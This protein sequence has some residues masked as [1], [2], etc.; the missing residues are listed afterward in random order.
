[1]PDQT[2]YSPT[3]NNANI[4]PALASKLVSPQDAAKLVNFDWQLVMANQRAWTA[5]F[6]KEIAG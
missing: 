3:V 5:R 1:M 6:N 4:P 2:Y